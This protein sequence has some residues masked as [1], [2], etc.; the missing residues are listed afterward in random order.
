M[1]EQEQFE[2]NTDNY[3]KN[4]C[5]HIWDKVSKKNGLTR[6]WSGVDIEA[7][8]TGIYFRLAGDLLI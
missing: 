5:Y 4:N 1:G 7:G 2:V 8:L 6:S 3:T